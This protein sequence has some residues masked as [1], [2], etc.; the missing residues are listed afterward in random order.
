M[1]MR[2][3]LMF[4]VVVDRLMANKDSLLE[5]VESLCLAK[6]SSHRGYRCGEMSEK[7]TKRKE[8]VSMES[9]GYQSIEGSQRRLICYGM[10]EGSRS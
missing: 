7:R 3:V 5:G 6:D 1:G 4:A 10:I 8:D 2:G 9:C